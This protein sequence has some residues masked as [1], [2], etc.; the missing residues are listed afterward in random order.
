MN[1]Q[2]YEHIVGLSIGEFK[3]NKTAEW[4]RH[5][6]TAGGAV[7][8]GSATYALTRLL[9]GSKKLSAILGIISTIPGGIGANMLY[10]S[11]S[12]DGSDIE[13]LRA[14]LLSPP[15]GA[16][17]WWNQDTGSTLAMHT[18]STLDIPNDSVLDL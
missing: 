16:D 11:L 9:G 13:K 8:V 17:T 18:D 10:D 14:S 12:D 3:L 1:K 4:K 6:A 2:A 7:G 15:S 5:L